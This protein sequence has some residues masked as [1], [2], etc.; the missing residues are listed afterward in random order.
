M[1]MALIDFS[2]YRGS[3]IGNAVMEALEDIGVINRYN[4]VGYHVSIDGVQEPTP[5]GMIDDMPRKH[6]IIIEKAEAHNGYTMDFEPQNF[7][8]YSDK[9]TVEH[10]KLGYTWYRHKVEFNINQLAVETDVEYTK[11]MFE[12]LADFSIKTFKSQKAKEQ[13]GGTE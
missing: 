4:I 9:H 7:D 8:G 3:E 5:I 6:N 10:D 12:T 11:R 13:K 2:N 1:G